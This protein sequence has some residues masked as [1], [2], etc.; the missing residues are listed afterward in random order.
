MSDETGMGHP[1]WWKVSAWHKK[2]YWERNKIEICSSNL[3]NS[4]VSEDE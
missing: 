2:E 4:L 1:D 3:N